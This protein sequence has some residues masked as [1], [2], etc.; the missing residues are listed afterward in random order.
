MK[1]NLIYTEHKQTGVNTEIVIIIY[2]KKVNN[3]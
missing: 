3:V 1:N 2:T